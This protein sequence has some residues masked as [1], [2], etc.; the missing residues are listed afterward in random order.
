[1]PTTTSLAF[2]EAHLHDFLRHANYLIHSTAPD[3]RLLFVNEAWKRTLGYTDHDIVQGLSMF[4]VIAPESRAHCEDSFRRVLRGESLTDIE[5]VFLTKDGQRVWVSGESNCHFDDGQPV[6]TRGIFRNV[7]QQRATEAALRDSEARHRQLFHG[8]GAIQLVIDADT[9]DIVDANPAAATF[10][11]YSCD[12]LRTMSIGTL[13][14]LRPDVLARELV[15]ATNGELTYVRRQHR[16]ATQG[17]REIEGYVSPVMA[18]GRRFLYAVIH[19]VTDRVRAE[20]ALRDSEQRFRAIFD[21][22]RV[23]IGLLAPN[24]TVLAANRTALDFIG[25]AEMDVL[26]RPFWTTPWWEETPELQAP[27]RAAIVQAAAGQLARLETT[28][29]G[30]DGRVITVEFSLTPIRDETG[31]VVLLVPEGYDITERLHAARL[32]DELIAL[33]S[34]ELRTPLSAISGG[35]QALASHAAFAPRERRFFDIAVRNTDRMLRL[36]ND[37]LDLER[38]ESGTVRLVHTSVEAGALLHHAAE[39]TLPVA[40][41][42]GVRLIVTPCTGRVWADVDRLMQVLTNLIANAVKFSPTESTVTLSATVHD[43]AVRFAIRDEGR[44]IPAEALDRIFG[45]FQQVYASDAHA[46]RG[47]GLGLAIAKALVEQHGGRIWVESVVGQG[48]T[49][50]FTIPSPATSL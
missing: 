45:R 21:S 37:L 5:A 31:K 50:F 8:N 7:T 1:M 3:G 16:S 39:A 42:A 33:V 46:Q 29:R 32:K 43:A 15:R 28:H 25:R 34:H 9:G 20:R 41:A 49:F 4:S 26:G 30:V 47:T 17:L 18:D 13:N 40:E 14:D 23:F 36:V 27:L 2:D 11:G 10:Y 24:G 35:L 48:S 6:A 19:D 22:S 44:G 12:V 38:I